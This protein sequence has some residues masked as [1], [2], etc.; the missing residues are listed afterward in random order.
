MPKFTLS[1]SF[2]FG[3]RRE[4]ITNFDSESIETILK[5]LN[6]DW[7]G[8]FAREEQMQADLIGWKKML[9]KINEVLDD[10]L[11]KQTKEE[12]VKKWL[13][14]LRNLAC[15]VD[16]LLDEF[17]TEAFQK[18]RGRGGRDPGPTIY[19]HPGLAFLRMKIFSKSEM[20]RAT[21]NFDRSRCLSQGGFA[22]VY[23]GVLHDNIQVAVKTYR[24]ADKIRITERE[25]LRII[26]QVN[27]KNVVKI[28]GLCLETEVPLLVYEFA[29]NGT[30]LDH[31]RCK[32]SQVLKTWKTC[33][34][35]A[36]ETASALDY[37]HSL[38]SPPIIHGDVKSANILLN[39]NYTAKV[40]D[41]ESSVLISSD[42]E[43]AMS[44]IL[45][46]TCGYLDPVCINTGK[47]TKKSD[48]YSFGVVL[49][50]LLTGKK[51]GSCM[52]LAS[53]KKISMVPY[54]LNSIKN[55]GLR[56]I[57]NFHVADES[58]MKEIEIVA[59]LASK[60][61]RIRGTERPTMKQVSEE[62]D[63]L[64]RLHE[65]FWAQKKNKETE[66]LLGESSS[67]ATAVIAQPDARTVVSIDIENYYGD[68]A[69]DKFDS[70]AMSKVKDVN[71]R[72]QDIASQID[73][74]GLKESSVE[75]STNARQRIST[76]PSVSE[77]NVLQISNAQRGGGG[78]PG[79]AN[80]SRSLIEKAKDLAFLHQPVPIFTKSE[81]LQAT[82]NY[83]T[84]LFLGEGG[85]ASVYKGVLPDCTPVA[86]KK[87]KVV[88]KI[89][90]NQVFQHELRVVSQINH[91]NVVKILGVCLETKV[92]LLVYE[93]VPNGTLFE[94]IHDKSSQVL[95]NWRTCLRIAAEI[96]SALDYLHS[97]ASPPIIHGDV[98]STNILL[99]DN[100]KAKLADFGSSMLISSDNQTAMT[101]KKIGTFFNLDPE[102]VITGKLTEKSD[103]YSFGVVLAELLT[104]LKPVSGMALASNEGISMVQYFLYSIENNSLR[105]ILN[106]QVADESEM[107]EIETVAELASKCLSLSG[108]RRPTMKQ[109]SEELDRLKISHEN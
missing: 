1:N 60:C 35:I 52:T 59:E 4:A 20:I 42:A 58:E 22:S 84:R 38:A 64:R 94:H 71:A 61:L 74:L 98:K 105:Q 101:T 32:S 48:V 78:D 99:D 3:S 5:K 49:A 86:V 9:L 12:S 47:L 82:G 103:L 93:F 14:N 79:P 87:P 72:F 63:R 2:R 67:Y 53:N 104:G 88:G 8:Q 76:T 85:F 45:I 39:D 95:R 102:Y 40:A 44:T 54:F 77:A 28:L 70:M 107:E 66:N 10:A 106:F 90:M 6:K 83:D 109:V 41:F 36:A 17:Q 89:P 27:H 51:P 31:I 30:L 19:S 16:Y 69:M 46:G 81:L 43:T 96:A 62:L 73:L 25:L 13:G 56:Q 92:P 24:R 34:R 23:K 26:S 15:D 108:R 18:I 33:L 55:N 57:L 75:K 100:Y 7:L 29:S 50:E 21:K 91:K 65:N 37:L 11:E 97:L 80:F 68:D